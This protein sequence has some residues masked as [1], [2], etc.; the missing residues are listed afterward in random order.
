MRVFR[1]FYFESKSKKKNVFSEIDSLYLSERSKSENFPG[2]ALDYSL[3]L[4]T[5]FSCVS[6]VFALHVLCESNCL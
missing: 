2:S 1:V 4:A 5:A 6:R 3:F